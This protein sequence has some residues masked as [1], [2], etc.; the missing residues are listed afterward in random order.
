VNFFTLFGKV[1]VDDK[2][3]WAE[4]EI[5]KRKRLTMMT[6]TFIQPRRDTAPLAQKREAT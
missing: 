5:G 2:L 1:N 3:G 6:G 4:K